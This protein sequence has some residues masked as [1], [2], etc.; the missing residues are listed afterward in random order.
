M[1]EWAYDFKSRL[2]IEAI[3]TA[4]NE[5]GPWQ[6]RLHDSDFYFNCRPGDHVHARVHEYPGIGLIRFS[7]LRATG[8]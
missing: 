5:A 8:G 7:G 3:G 4:F 2:S 6:W 1:P